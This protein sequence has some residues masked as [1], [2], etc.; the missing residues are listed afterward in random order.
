MASTQG[1]VPRRFLWGSLWAGVILIAVV[2]IMDSLPAAKRDTPSATYSHG[3]LSIVIPYRAVSAGAGYLTLELLDPED[4]VLVHVTRYARV[5][6]GAGSWQRNLRLERP[7]SVED[8]VWHRLRYRF[9]YAA[10][11]AGSLEGIESVSQI[12]RTPVIHILGQQSC[13][14]ERGLCEGGGHRLQE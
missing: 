2:G 11:G 5:R 7:L 13:G 10:G 3:R 12:L 4:R 8:L 14:G 9:E 1:T 6:E